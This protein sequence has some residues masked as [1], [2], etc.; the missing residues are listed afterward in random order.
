MKGDTPSFAIFCDAKR[1]NNCTV[2]VVAKKYFV[3]KI[4]TLWL[5]IVSAKSKEVVTEQWMGN[6]SLLY[7]VTSMRLPV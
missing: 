1:R 2:S 4:W 7:P 5:S 6:E 3:F